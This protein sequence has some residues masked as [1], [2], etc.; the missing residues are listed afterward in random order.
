MWRFQDDTHTLLFFM[1]HRNWSTPRRGGGA[2]WILCLAFMSMPAV[3]KVVLSGTHHYQIPARLSGNSTPRTNFLK[4]HVNL[5]SLPHHTSSDCSYL[6]FSGHI[7]SNFRVTHKNRSDEVSRNIGYDSE[8]GNLCC[9]EGASCFQVN[10]TGALSFLQN[11]LLTRAP[12][13]QNPF[14]KLLS[15]F[16]K[17]EAR[18]PQV[19]LNH[20][21]QRQI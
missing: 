17:G 14:L 10:D 1:S 21:F 20:L 2:L 7:L 8:A 15:S 13:E 5:Y 3:L 6:S 12:C 18:A 4:Q 9:S 11:D 16:W 19:P